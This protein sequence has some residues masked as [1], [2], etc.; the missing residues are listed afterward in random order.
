[1]WGRYKAILINRE[2]EVARGYIGSDFYKEIVKI[3]VVESKT[4]RSMLLPLDHTSERKY[5]QSSKF[6]MFITQ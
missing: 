6:K 3:S 1:M 4:F 5:T 2:L